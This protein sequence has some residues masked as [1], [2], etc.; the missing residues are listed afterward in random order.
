[1]LLRV[2]LTY[3]LA[4]SFP[5][6]AKRE[7][8]EIKVTCLNSMYRIELWALIIHQN[9][10]PLSQCVAL[11]SW[12][13]T[14]KIKWGL[15]Y[16]FGLLSPPTVQHN[17]WAECVMMT[18]VGGFPGWKKQME[19]WEGRRKGGWFLSLPRGKKRRGRLSR[20]TKL[21]LSPRYTDRRPPLGSSHR[22]NSM[23]VVHFIFLKL[24]RKSKHTFS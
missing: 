21:S 24:N 20:T 5:V 12:V 4:V 19:R 13:S 16:C 17:R 10:S 2:S 23:K 11:T 6:C 14:W 9:W 22:G 8:N 1:M 3:W 18:V 7:C 15:N